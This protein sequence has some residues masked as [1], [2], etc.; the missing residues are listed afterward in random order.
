MAKRPILKL[1]IIAVGISLIISMAVILSNYFTSTRPMYIQNNTGTDGKPVNNISVSATGKVTVTPDIVT[2]NVGYEID[3]SKLTDVQNELTNRSNALAQAIKALG[4]EDKDIQTATYS[5]SPQT[6]YDDNLN[7]YVAD[8]FGGT[9]VISVK[10]RNIKD[11]GK[12][13]DA[14]IDAGANTISNVEYTVDN[15]DTVK[16]Q[17]RKLAAQYAKDKAEVLAEGSGVSVGSLI[18]I[19]ENTPTY[20]N[21]N[22]VMYDRA[23]SESQAAP[24]IS[25]GSLTIEVTVMAVYGII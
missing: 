16:Q 4:V 6:R 1:G 18:S 15:I 25:P 8:G 24:A 20:S 12:I 2:F 13:I 14:A 9:L 7:T 10:V 19:S 11:A 21:N 17:A 22:Y 3:R 5:I 23:A